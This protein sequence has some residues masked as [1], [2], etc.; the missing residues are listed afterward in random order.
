MSASPSAATGTWGSEKRYVR[1][2]VP[3]FEAE[4][5]TTGDEE[6]EDFTAPAAVRQVVCATAEVAMEK[7]AVKAITS[8]H[9]ARHAGFNAV[10]LLFLSIVFPLSFKQKTMYGY[11]RKSMALFSHIVRVSSI[12]FRKLFLRVTFG[13]RRART[14]GSFSL[15][16]RKRK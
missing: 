6:A 13:R 15:S 16:Q 2:C 10:F 9:A 5:E 8:R 11:T 7:A 3:S 12:V 4:A 14:A 1:L